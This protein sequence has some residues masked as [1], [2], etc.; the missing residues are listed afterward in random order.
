MG[1]EHKPGDFVTWKEM[2]ILTTLLDERAG[3]QQRAL[4]TAL[5]AQQRAVDAAVQSVSGKDKEGRQHT[6]LLCII[7]GL[8]LNGVAVLLQAITALRSA[9]H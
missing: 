7:L 2:D 5:S 6:L 4:D 8:V 9:G 1:A 3:N